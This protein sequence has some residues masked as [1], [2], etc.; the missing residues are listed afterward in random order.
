M[1]PKRI[2]YIPLRISQKPLLRKLGRIRNNK[3]LS[4][5]VRKQINKAIKEIKKNSQPRA[6]FQLF[7]VSTDEQLVSIGQKTT[8]N[9]KKLAKIIEP[10]KRVVVFLVT[11]GKEID[12]IIDNALEQQPY[13]GF[14][15]DAAASLA[16]E[17]SAEYVQEYI[18]R[19]YTS[20]KEKTLRYSP[21]FCGWSITEQKKLFQTLPSDKVN[22][23]LSDSYFMS[24]QKSIS[25]LIGI[26]SGD[27]VYETENIC[28]Q[29]PKIDCRHRKFQYN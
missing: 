11:L 16:I 25:G 13:F 28:T 1:S 14:I 20:N 27:Q 29:C 21:G 9:S 19:H 6:V 3:S 22:V 24:P 18:D 4:V 5:R 23:Q 17:S 10:C 2:D 12:K 7:P 26:G 15:L 8:F